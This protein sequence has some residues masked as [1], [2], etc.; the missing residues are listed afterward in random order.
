MLC[1]KLYCIIQTWDK[2]TMLK[3]SKNELKI[4]SIIKLL[5]APSSWSSYMYY[6]WRKYVQYKFILLF[7]I[8]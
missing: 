7:D 4:T 6:E 1:I 3:Y 8:L 2:N 5:K